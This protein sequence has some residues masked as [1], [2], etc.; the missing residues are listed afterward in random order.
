MVVDTGCRFWRES[1]ICTCKVHQKT[2]IRSS[3]ILICRAAADSNT[4]R[5]FCTKPLFYLRVLKTYISFG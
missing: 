3:M 5:M 4:K 2:I 1:H